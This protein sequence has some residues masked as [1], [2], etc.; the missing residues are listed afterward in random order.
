MAAGP[1]TGYLTIQNFRYGL[2]ARRSELTSQ[3]GTLLRAI[4]CH[5]NQGAEIEK[6]K[7][8]IKT[9]MPTGVFLGLSVTNTQYGF[10]SVPLPVMP[11]GFTYQQLT[12]PLGSAMTALVGAT[13]FNNLPFVLA[14]FGADGTFCFYNGTLVADFIG[15]LVLAGLTTSAE[16]ANNLVGLINATT[17]YTAAIGGTAETVTITGEN[18][19]NYS[20]TDTV[21]SALGSISEFQEN[22]AT[23]GSQ[24]SSAIG[25]FVISACFPG[26]G[27]TL[28]NVNFIYVNG[29]STSIM[30]AKVNATT[31]PTSLAAAVA[32]SVNAKITT[33]G[34]YSALANGNTVN[35]YAPV[36]TVPNGYELHVGCQNSS[37]NDGGV[38]LQSCLFTFTLGAGSIDITNIASAEQGNIDTTARNSTGFA[39]VNL[40][41]QQIAT[42]IMTTAGQFAAVAVNNQLY[43][44]LIGD[45]TSPPYTTDTITVTFTASGGATVGSIG[46]LSAIAIPTRVAANQSVSIK[47]SGG[48]SPYTYAWTISNPAIFM[49]SQTSFSNSFNTNVAPTTNKFGGF[50]VVT[51]TATC[52]V[53]DSA[54]SKVSV[55]VAVNITPS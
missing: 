36:G 37:N 22:T 50:N 23:A 5:V 42:D 29:I 21:T 14:T 9:A 18:G 27:A 54:G 40:W 35:I 41:L 11:A 48:Q 33:N 6:R 28:A 4:D 30:A 25:S 24:A 44:S 26:T 3:P 17:N 8:F 45:D 38:C 13:Q 43:I 51:G 1:K 49:S 32:A 31:D 53:S 52:I 16:Q 39:T 12:S 19:S 15:G 7:A 47:A 2:D 34:G 55:T 10:G 20:M 46:S